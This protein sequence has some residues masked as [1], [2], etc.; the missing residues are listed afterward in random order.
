[1]ALSIYTASD[2]DMDTVC[3]KDCREPLTLDTDEIAENPPRAEG[4]IFID[5]Q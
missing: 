2:L 3:L 5:D 4:S 1:M